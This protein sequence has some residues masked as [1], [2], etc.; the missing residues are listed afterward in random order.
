[1]HGTPNSHLKN[2]YITKHYT[3]PQTQEDPIKLGRSL[4]KKK[5]CHSFI[6]AGHIQS[7]LLTLCLILGKGFL[8]LV[9]CG[10]MY[11]H[12]AK[13]NCLVFFKI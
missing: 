10:E 13:L 5:P 12:D 1:M 6:S 3:Q 4:K 11:Y 9:K 8:P 7:T 2:H